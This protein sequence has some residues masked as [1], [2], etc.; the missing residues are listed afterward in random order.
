LD[1]TVNQQPIPDIFNTRIETTDGE[2]ADAWTDPSPNPPIQP[3]PSP[4]RPSL[5]ASTVLQACMSQCGDD[6]E[7]GLLACE[8][9]LANNLERSLFPDEYPR[10]TPPTRPHGEAEYPRNTSNQ[11]VPKRV[12]AE[13]ARVDLIQYEKFR[14]TL[15]PEERPKL[16]AMVLHL[17][18]GGALHH[19]REH[20]GLAVGLDGE[21][22]DHRWAEYDRRC[23]ECEAWQA[24]STE[25]AERRQAASQA[26][27]S[28]RGQQPDLDA[29]DSLLLRAGATEKEQRTLSR[30]RH[31]AGR[32]PDLEEE[33]RDLYERVA[34]RVHSRI[35]REEQ[36]DPEPEQPQ[37]PGGAAMSLDQFGHEHRGKGSK[38]G[39]F[40]PKGLGGSG[41][42][43]PPAP[44]KPSISGLQSGSE[45]PPPAIPPQVAAPPPPPLAKTQPPAPVAPTA[46]VG[47]PPDQPPASAEPVQ[48]GDMELATLLSSGKSTPLAAGTSKTYKVETDKGPFFV[49]EIK[50]QF[51]QRKLDPM[52]GAKNEADIPKLAKLDTLDIASAAET[53]YNN[54]P[55]MAM[56]WLE[57]AALVDH[58]NWREVLDTLDPHDLSRNILF[59]YLANVID[60]HEG[61]YWVTPDKKLYSI[62]HE[63]AFMGKPDNLKDAINTEMNTLYLEHK[64]G[65]GLPTDR[66]AKDLLGAA[67]RMVEFLRQGGRESE[68][69]ALEARSKTLQSYVDGGGKN[70]RDFLK[71]LR[72]QHNKPSEVE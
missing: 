61:N 23:V 17:Q 9:I 69:A 33:L 44:S 34:E 32:R 72:K 38:G 54:R 52:R 68:A 56:D 4:P 60:R 63:W 71:Y 20:H 50:S 1:G 8:Y 48:H 7:A 30:I 10:P 18:A 24:R 70:M 25:R 46:P 28:M 58:E 45:P 66:A 3:I 40:A 2:H 39:Q 42:G 31:R 12:I 53:T 62:D 37:E 14:N 15:P 11:F 22:A 49:K 35:D 13:A 29:I 55:A 51:K 65:D 57:G 16:D 47:G 36:E 21:V 67:P 6:T 19:P 27:R 26:V 43:A 59:S 41:G 5:S 64:D